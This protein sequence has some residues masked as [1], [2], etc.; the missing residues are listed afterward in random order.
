MPVEQPVTAHT[1]TREANLVQLVVLHLANEEFGIPI[2]EVRE[3][4]KMAKI[5]FVPDASSSFIKGLIN[6][7]GEIVAVVDLGERFFLKTERP[8]EAKHIVITKQKD[9]LFGLIVEEVVEVLRIETSEIKRPP[10]IITKL[11]REY[12]SGVITLENR[13]I[14]VLDMAKVLSEEEMLRVV[15]KIQESH[16]TQEAAAA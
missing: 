8:M 1:S 13:L 14:I 5:T 4:I 9:S 16:E 12:V 3:I 6:V 11:N 7:R 10:E 15:A 2:G